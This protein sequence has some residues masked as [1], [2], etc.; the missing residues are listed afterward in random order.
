MIDMENSK[1][2]AP[3][4]SNQQPKKE[5]KISTP[6]AAP[7][8]VSV[9]LILVLHA[10]ELAAWQV[11]PSGK[12]K[13]LQIKGDKRLSVH[14]ASALESAHAD[15]AERLR[16]DGIAV[17]Y[18]HWLAD[19]RG[20]PWCASCVAKASSASETTAWQL[21]AWEWLS[22]RF[23]LE[24]ASP[25]EATKSFTDQLLPWLVTSDDAALR[26]HLQ[27][28]RESEHHSETDRLA[29]ARNT[30]AQENNRLHTQ[31]AALQ[32]MDAERLVSFLPALFPR[33]FT[34]LG[35]TDLALLCG[36][37]QPLGIPN[38]YP[39]PSEETLRTLQKHFRALPQEHQRQIV[40]FVA[41]LPQRQ[42]LQPRPEMRELVQELEV[43]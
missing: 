3:K 15:I 11:S 40:R 22:N 43:H 23:G 10:N 17:A 20:R 26:Q 4:K 28:T 1:K 37:V 31:N 35:A 5:Q 2:I 42:K 29:A 12:P 27:Q 39:E 9:H 33:V 25:W 13:A 36:H 32:Q 24:N 7:A 19:A 14:N 18:T 21:L 6:L 8:P 34:V 38:P 30:L 41:D 16:G